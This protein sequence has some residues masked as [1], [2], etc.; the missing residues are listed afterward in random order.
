VLLLSFP[1]DGLLREVCSSPPSCSLCP[2]ASCPHAPRG[3][4]GCPSASLLPRTAR[5]LR[6]FYAGLPGFTRLLSWKFMASRL[7]EK[8]GSTHFG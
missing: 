7:S 1:H 4:G 3:T 6:V 8:Q 5:A 2:L